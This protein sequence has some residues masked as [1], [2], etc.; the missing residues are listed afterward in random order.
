MQM[1]Q[2]LED[3]ISVH[4]TQCCILPVNCC[5]AVRLESVFFPV[6]FCMKSGVCCCCCSFCF[7][8]FFSWM[9]KFSPCCCCCLSHTSAVIQP[10]LR[11]IQ[12]KWG[13]ASMINKWCTCRGDVLMWIK[14]LIHQVTQSLSGSNW[15]RG[16][17]LKMIFL[18]GESRFLLL[19]GFVIKPW[20]DSVC[21]CVCSC[22]WVLL[23]FLFFCFGLTGSDWRGLVSG[24]REEEEQEA[25]GC[26]FHLLLLSWNKLLPCETSFPS[27]NENTSDLIAHTKTYFWSQTSTD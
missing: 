16:Q 19:L 7:N 25:A 9:S 8:F 18:I 4:E 23:L 11:K 1:Q 14:L 20:L 17:H 2:R 27:S 21:V 13:N 6:M 5:Q 12:Q 15:K 10:Q 26:L 22:S 24:H 3:H